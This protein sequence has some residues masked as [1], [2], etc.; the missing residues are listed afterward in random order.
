MSQPGCDYNRMVLGGGGME[1]GTFV[2]AR[3]RGLG[4]LYPWVCHLPTLAIVKRMRMAVVSEPCD[5]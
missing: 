4:L 5:R 2:Q 3:A 1:T